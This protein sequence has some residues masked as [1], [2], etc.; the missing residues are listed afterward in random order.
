MEPAEGW[1]S[2]WRW[3]AGTE[4]ATLLEDQLYREMLVGHPLHRLAPIAIARCD[5][6]DDVLFKA[7]DDRVAEVHLTWGERH[8]DYPTTVFRTTLN[9]WATAQVEE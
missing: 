8:P 3:I 5:G 1:P 7:S 4:E 2:T 9:D 6:S